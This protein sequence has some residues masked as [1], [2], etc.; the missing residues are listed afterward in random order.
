M[1]FQNTSIE[2]V[3]YQAAAVLAYNNPNLSANDIMKLLGAT[4]KTEQHKV[5]LGWWKAAQ[6]LGLVKGYAQPGIPA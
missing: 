2:T 6:K 5:R 4:T 1:N 3:L